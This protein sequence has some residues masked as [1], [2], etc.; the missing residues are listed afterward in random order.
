M[1]DSPESS[2]NAYLDDA[3]NPSQREQFEDLLRNDPALRRLLEQQQAI[4]A[5]LRRTHSIARTEKADAAII[6]QSFPT[7]TT[8]PHP[9]L[10]SAR[11]KLP[12]AAALVAMTFAGLW[13]SWSI[14]Q[15][16]PIVDAYAPQ[17]WRNFET[18]YND[19]LRNG[20]KPDWI[21]RNEKEFERTFARRFRSPL[22]LAAL[23]SGIT[24][25]GISYCNTI[26]EGSINVLGRVNGTPVMIFVDR[27][28][29]P[30]KAMPEPGSK[31]NVFH[32]KLD[33]LELYE[34]TPLV[35]PKVL[36]YFY[37]PQ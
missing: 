16:A 9:V 34:L 31:L 33:G 30:P 2:L 8:I 6:A 21:C 25:G 37:I 28:E 19:T 22:L 32:R 20:F 23:P 12:A 17:P 24:A 27:S 1:N 18:V 10:R 13:Y 26:T 11:W 14:S 5:S 4:D 35:E 3:L 36:P 15:P 29:A 7:F